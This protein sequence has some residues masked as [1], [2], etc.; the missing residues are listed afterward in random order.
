MGAFDAVFDGGIRCSVR[1]FDGTSME[2]PIVGIV[3]AMATQAIT[4]RATTI[5]AIN[6][7]DSHICRSLE[8][9]F[10]NL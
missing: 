6:I 5:L 10:V 3:Q 4:I 2:C 1:S 9:G 7:D 8:S